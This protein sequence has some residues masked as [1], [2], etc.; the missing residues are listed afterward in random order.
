MVEEGSSGGILVKENRE[1]REIISCIEW[2]GKENKMGVRGSG[3]MVLSMMRMSV[4]MRERGEGTN[5][6]KERGPICRIPKAVAV[7]I[8]VYQCVCY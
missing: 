3:C 6:P 8:S 1:K 4:M 7:C 2:V 5:G